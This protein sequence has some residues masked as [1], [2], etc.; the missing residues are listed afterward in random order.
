M[1]SHGYGWPQQATGLV[2]GWLTAKPKLKRLRGMTA[3]PS[4]N[5]RRA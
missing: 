1:I 4:G 5:L 3:H 2:L